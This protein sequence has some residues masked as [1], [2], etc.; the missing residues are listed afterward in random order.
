MKKYS[1]PF[2][3]ISLI[4]GSFITG[5]RAAVYG[6]AL[7]LFIGIIFLGIKSPK[8]VLGKGVVAIVF[9]VISLTAL[10][11]LKPEF[12]AAFNKR[13]ENSSEYS[14]NDE[15]A[16]RVKGNFFNWTN[17]I[18]DVDLKET[19]LGKGLAVMS[20]G[21]DKFSS[22]AYSIR[23]GQHIWTETDMAT[24]VWEGGI[25][26]LILWYGF[27]IGVIIFC[28][29]IWKSL[30]EKKFGFAV[31]FLM[32]FLIVTG[33]GGTLSIQPPL[34]IWWWM[35]VGAIITIKNFDKRKIQAPFTKQIP[36]ANN[37]PQIYNV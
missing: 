11:A 13:S 1:I 24:T 4:I 21:S 29:R 31:S 34:S 18:F 35:C 26:L 32:G 36:N 14:S 10:Q 20:N 8:V 16:G 15:L 3:V 7:C 6:S 37:M 25:Y 33:I 17:W 27:R 19:I 9:L 28:Y 30:K 22:Y 12:F 2:M 5:S 23:S